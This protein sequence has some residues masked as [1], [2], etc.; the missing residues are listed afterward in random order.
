MPEASY[1]V[2]YRVRGECGSYNIECP[3]WE[4]VVRSYE[5]I[6]KYYGYWDI[7]V[8]RIQ[9]LSFIPLSLDPPA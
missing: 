2:R 6:S 4:D 7:R 8:V 5:Q 9:S 1:E 3:T